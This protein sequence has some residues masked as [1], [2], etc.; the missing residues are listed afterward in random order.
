[1][2]EEGLGGGMNHL[3]LLDDTCISRVICYMS[4]DYYIAA[5]I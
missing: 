2:E 3:Q 1:M 5:D 4:V